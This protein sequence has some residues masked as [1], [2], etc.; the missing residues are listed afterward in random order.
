MKKVG[1]YVDILFVNIPC[2]QL[3]E[4]FFSDEQNF[5]FPHFHNKNIF[6]HLLFINIKKWNFLFFKSFC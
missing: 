6:I 4:F 5:F 2:N 1:F 3:P